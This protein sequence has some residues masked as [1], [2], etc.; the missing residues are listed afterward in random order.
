MKKFLG[1]MV[2]LISV[3]IVT[4][5]SHA[6]PA[7]MNATI[8]KD[9]VLADL[10]VSRFMRNGEVTKQSRPVLFSCLGLYSEAGFDTNPGHG[11]CTQ[12]STYFYC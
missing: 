6:I 11:A 8:S 9:K 12:D 2:F 5:K 3:W 10:D 7:A 4:G 1:F